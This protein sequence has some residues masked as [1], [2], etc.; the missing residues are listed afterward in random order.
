[1]EAL[2]VILGI[3][4]FIILLIT[5]ISALGI[6]T[7]GKI[8][9]KQYYP[10]SNKPDRMLK[11]I[12]YVHQ[13]A[14]ENDFEFLAYYWVKPGFQRIFMGVWQRMDRPTFL[15]TYL[16]P[17]QYGFTSLTD[18][19]TEFAGEVSL[20]STNSKAAQL[21]PKPPKSYHQTFSR[22]DLDELWRRHIEM[23]N[24][25]MDAGGA[26]L[27]YTEIQFEESLVRDHQ[28][29]IRYIRSIPY[30]YLLGTYWYFVRR[31][32][33]HNKPVKTLHGKGMIKLPNE[34]DDSQLKGG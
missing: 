17:N 32:L 18:I 11:M 30:W 1:M 24:F 10:K 5:I 13:W 6:I 3:V 22:I 21:Y 26:E 2:L 4:G 23:E 28:K 27:V 15:C 7:Q 8:S 14:K 16:V 19:F 33:W 20:T 9:L 29:D 25:L 31:N 34:I 12:E